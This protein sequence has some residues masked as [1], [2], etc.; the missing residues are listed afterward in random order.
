MIGP[1]AMAYVG[2]IT[3]K[4]QEG[5]YQG[6]LS[7]AFY[8]GLGAG[9]L[10]GGAVYHVVG[11]ETVFLLMSVMAFIPCLLCY[12]YLPELKPEI[13][14]RTRMRGA[15]VHPR[16]QANLFFRFVNCFPYAAFM[17]FLPVIATTQYGYT[18]TLAA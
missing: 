10:I 13:S 8:L 11:L 2:D 6:R 5:A 9:P 1:V 4:G 17:V 12:R 16:M 15:F 3:P 7:N 18:T 14:T